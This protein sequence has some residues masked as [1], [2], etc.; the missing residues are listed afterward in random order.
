VRRVSVT[1]ISSIS[2]LFVQSVCP[3]RS[4]LLHPVPSLTHST[5]SILST[6]PSML[7]LPVCT[8]F[9]RLFTTAF[10]FDILAE[11]NSL[12]KHCS[13]LMLLALCYQRILDGL[14][15]SA[16]LRLDHHQ[17]NGLYLLPEKIQREPSSPPP[18]AP[19]I[20]C[21]ID[22][23]YN[24]N[25]VMNICGLSLATSLSGRRKMTA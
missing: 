23:F 9:L 4:P 22:V 14:R 18:M 10:V 13:V 12:L 19:S 16:H 7:H 6:G 15:R 1:R 17:W 8:P 3:V 24:D 11:R 5:S 20:D 25:D 2:A 21:I